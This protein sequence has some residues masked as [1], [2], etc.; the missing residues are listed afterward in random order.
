M[1]N[2]KK[3]RR[4]AHRP[5]NFRVA[6]VE[7]ALRATAGIF[8]RAAKRLR[9][10]PTTVKNYVDRH[11]SLQLALE[12]IKEVTLDLAEDGLI[13]LIKKKHPTALIFYLKTKGKHRGYVER[14]EITG[15]DGSPIAIED[16]RGML[17]ERAAKLVGKAEPEAA[18]RGDPVPSSEGG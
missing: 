9:C 4:P 3:S 17:A 10:S 5:P 2:T 18:D 13:A 7:A 11:E 1:K 14:S 8:S 6:T 16:A 12:E 15:V